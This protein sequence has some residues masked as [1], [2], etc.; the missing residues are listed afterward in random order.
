MVRNIVLSH[1]AS[2]PESQKQKLIKRAVNENLEKNLL[3][4]GIHKD[5]VKNILKIDNNIID[6]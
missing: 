4:R 1:K 2:L 6:L 5:T 3:S